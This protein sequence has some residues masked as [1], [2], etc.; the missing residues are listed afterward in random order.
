M[1]EVVATNRGT[2]L[3]G[4]RK[5]WKTS[6][7]ISDIMTEVRTDHTPNTCLD[8]YLRTNLLGVGFATSL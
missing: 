3:E 4:A 5:S 8:R 1:R 2:C 6:V 7:C